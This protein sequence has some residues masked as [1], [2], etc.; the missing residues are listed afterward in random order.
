MTPIPENARPGDPRW[1]IA[2][3][4]L[5]HGLIM[6]GAKPKIIERFTDM[7]HRKVKEAYLA[8]RGIGPPAGPV[9]RGSARYFAGPSKR[10]SEAL[11][12]QCAIF[13]E[14]FGRIGKSTPT[15]VHRGWRLL[16]A[17]DAYLALTETFIQVAAVKRLDINEAYSLL[18]YCGFLTLPNG[19]ELQRTL[20]PVCCIYYPVVVKEQLGCPVCAMN[21]TY[22]RRTQQGT[23]PEP[24]IPTRKAL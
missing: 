5:A 11:R 24:E 2:F 14:C 8:L 3:L 7:S 20:C 10:T 17:F 16:A 9:M 19:A 18:T 4:D 15:P 6:A 12:I 23:P 21:A 1:A 22:Q 13:L